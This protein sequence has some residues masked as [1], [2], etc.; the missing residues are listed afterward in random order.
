VLKNIFGLER[1]IRAG[2]R[3]W[4]TP[5]DDDALDLLFRQAR[6]HNGWQDR[7]VADDLLRQAVEIA[8]MGPYQRQLLAHV[9]F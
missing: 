4:L 9:G 7:P 8:K 6:A 5:L 2:L 1:V 3:D